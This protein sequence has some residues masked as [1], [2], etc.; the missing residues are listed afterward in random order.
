MQKNFSKTREKQ[1]PEHFARLTTDTN[2][3]ERQGTGR[4]W[5]CSLP[6]PFVAFLPN[7]LK[8]Q[9][10]GSTRVPDT[11]EIAEKS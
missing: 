10:G 4:A 11:E 6:L 2:S 5:L 9:A 1:T 8:L 7:T 3:W